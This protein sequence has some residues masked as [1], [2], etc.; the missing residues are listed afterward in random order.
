MC[1]VHNTA[2]GDVS[3]SENMIAVAAANSYQVVW[4]ACAAF[5][6]HCACHALVRTVCYVLS[7]TLSLY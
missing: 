1:V 3:T 2:D 7:L 5:A 4:C 6:H